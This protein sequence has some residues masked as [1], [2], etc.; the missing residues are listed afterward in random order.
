[1]SACD[2]SRAIAFFQ[3]VGLAKNKRLL[4]HRNEGY[5]L[6]SQ[7]KVYGSVYTGD[8]FCGFRRFDSIGRADNRHIR[9]SPHRGKILEGLR[10]GAVRSDRYAAM[11]AGYLYVTIIITESHPEDPVCIGPKSGERTDKRE[12]AY[13]AQPCGRTCDILLGYAEIEKSFRKFLLEIFG[14]GRIFQVARE[15]DY[16]P[17]FPPQLEQRLAETVTRSLHIFSLISSSAFESSSPF[18][19]LPCHP[20]SPSIKETP[21]P[22]IVRAAMKVGLSFILPER[23]KAFMISS[24]SCPFISRV[25]HPKSLSFPANGS[26]FFIW[27]TGPFCWTPL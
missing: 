6:S 7:P 4:F 26:S 14:A 17:V 12:E 16:I 18:G 2:D 15:D 24:K 13:F 8:R 22:F 25:F 11:R 19:A 5:G 1:M 10:R 20:G 27:A 23:S 21:L 3:Y 9:K